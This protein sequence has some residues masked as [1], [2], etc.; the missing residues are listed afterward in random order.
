MVRIRLARLGA[1]KR[2]FYRVIVADSRSPRDGSNLE[3]VGH[4]NPLTDPPVLNIDL[5]RVDHWLGNGAQPSD[6]V[7]DL[8]K[9]ARAA[10][11]QA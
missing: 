8:I 11:A 4:F 10:G 9:K 1:K 2:P 5:A 3:I 6:T 7:R